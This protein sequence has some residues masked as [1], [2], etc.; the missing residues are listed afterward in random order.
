MQTQ[1]I[2]SGISTEISSDAAGVVS[3]ISML[4]A[5]AAETYG[6]VN[7]LRSSAGQTREDAEG[8]LLQ[9]MTEGAWYCLQRKRFERAHN[10]D[11]IGTP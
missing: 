8:V 1:E 10:S 3:E 5:N 9:A 11:Q 2:V 6:M 4:M 7:A